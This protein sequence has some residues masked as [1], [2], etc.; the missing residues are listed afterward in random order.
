MRNGCVEKFKRIFPLVLMSYHMGKAQ[1]LQVQKKSS[2]QDIV[3]GVIDTGLDLQ[4]EQLKDSIW[5]NHGESGLD[6][7]GR[8]KS[9]NGIDDDGNGYIDDVH[10]WNFVDNNNKVYDENGH[11]THVAGIIK[12]QFDKSVRSPSSNVKFMVLKFYDQKIKGEQSMMNGIKA[13]EYAVKMKAKILNYSGGGADQ[14]SAELDAIR[15]AAEQKIFLVAAAGNNHVNSDY[16]K[17]FPAGYDSDNIISVAS[18][19]RDFKLSAFSNFGLNS[20]DIAAPGNVILSSAPQNKLEYLSGTSQ[21]T[22]FVTGRLAGVVTN[23]TEC[24]ID[25]YKQF[26]FSQAKKVNSLKGLTKTQLA[27]VED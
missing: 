25:V 10:G 8:G 14:D 26:L 17:Y 19:D 27:L 12:K 22:A 9:N 13:I 2:Q 7:K 15:K 3:V 6:D 21:A 18:I 16:Q 20:V 24:S 5:V 11:G 4:H 1:G 23:C